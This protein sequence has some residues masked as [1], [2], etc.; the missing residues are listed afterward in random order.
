MQLRLEANY[1]IRGSSNRERVE[2][3]GTCI[4][5]VDFQALSSASFD[6]MFI[7]CRRTELKVLHI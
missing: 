3:Q 2:R 7:A 6:S 1:W 4:C 5:F